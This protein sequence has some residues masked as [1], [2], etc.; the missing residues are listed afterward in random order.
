[1]TCPECASPLYYDVRYF[2]GR[3]YEDVLCCS[4][5]KCDYLR[6]VSDHAAEAEAAQRTYDEG[7]REWQRPFPF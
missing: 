1:M 6:I 2:G 4:K 3:G 7:Y 5:R